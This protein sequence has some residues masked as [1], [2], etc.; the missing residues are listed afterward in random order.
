M[1]VLLLFTGCLLARGQAGQQAQQNVFRAEAR[2]VH[3][4][5]IGT[6]PNGRPVPDLRRDEILVSENGRTQQLLSFEPAV[7]AAQPVEASALNAQ[8]DPAQPR[9]AGGLRA[10][11]PPPG[12]TNRGYIVLAVDEASTDRSDR[13]MAL[14]SI[15]DWI[16]KY[17]AENDQVALVS[18]GANVRVWRLF[19]ADTRLLLPKVEEMKAQAGQG[20][21]D[22]MID[23]V[24]EKIRVCQN[25]A[26]RQCRQ[27][28]VRAFKNEGE[29]LLQRRKGLLLSLIKMLDVFQ[30]EKRVV[31][32]GAGFMTNPGLVAE[33]VDEAFTA[34]TAADPRGY[35][36]SLLA[37]VNQPDGLQDVTSA[38]LRASVTF[39]TIDCRGLRTDPP[40]GM[41]DH[42]VSR[43]NVFNPGNK[44]PNAAVAVST[45]LFH[46]TNDSLRALGY[47]TGGRAF[48]NEN[49]L[50]KSTR[51]AI[52]EL[53]GTYYATYRPDDDNFDGKYRKIEIHSLRSRIEVHTRAGYFAIDPKPLSM[54]ANARQPQLQG[55]AYKVP[56]AI[57]LT[58]SELSWAGEPEKRSD[59]VAVL[60]SLFNARKDL[61]STNVLYLELREPKGQVARLDLDVRAGPG[62]YACVLT[63]SE[64][65]TTNFGTATL[66]L[67]M[68]PRDR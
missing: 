56:L 67:N 29:M 47:D 37:S 64:L 11:S 22:N 66:D 46:M 58:A 12:L 30:G 7:R 44:N 51:L 68:P 35:D 34:I 26:N 19:T 55:S 49:D 45:E 28:A 39:Y 5:I 60:M 57:E 38:A 23:R 10:A 25:E 31:Y 40:M 59:Q 15:G 33:K 13:L 27:A 32:Y 43:S 6:T 4:T 16:R 42:A 3:L 2:L 9:N 20:T 8:P 54:R 1:L 53:E 41:P 61:V 21:D 18:L 24:I 65:S 62:T 48:L 17:K 50:L 63:V 36:P 52:G 14:K